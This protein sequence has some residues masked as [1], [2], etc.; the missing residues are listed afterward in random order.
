MLKALTKTMIQ[1]ALDEEMTE[2]LGYGQRDLARR[3]CGNSRNPVLDS[4]E[5]QR[6]TVMVEVPRGRDGGFDPAIVATTA[7]PGRC[8][9]DRVLHGRQGADHQRGVRALRGDLWRH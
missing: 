1:T 3:G 6:G 4:A 5:R 2:H 9:H 8:G 7:T